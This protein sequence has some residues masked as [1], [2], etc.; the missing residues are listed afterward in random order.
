MAARQRPAKRKKKPSRLQKY[1]RTGTLVFTLLMTV[2]FGY[3]IYSL[4]FIAPRAK[5]EAAEIEEQLRIQQEEEEQRRLQ[6]EAELA[7][8]AEERRKQE[9]YE[10][11]VNEEL[12]KN[13]L[14]ARYSDASEMLVTGIGDSVM[15]GAINELY[16]TFP[17]GY[18]DAV[19]GRT[20]YSGKG[21]ISAM[22]DN[23]TL[24]EVVVFNLGTNSYI[25][26][27][28]IEELVS[29]CDDRPT[30]WITTYGVSNDSTEK[31]RAVAQQNDHVH[32]VE[33]GALA[34][35]H[36]NSYILADGLHPTHEG[37]LA[38]AE[39][40]KETINQEVLT[41]KITPEGNS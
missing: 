9:E 7:A 33:W 5:V 27:S 23:G 35:E 14:L 12:E 21:V 2:F 32:I 22:K 30:F 25:E 8:L 26:E 1:L 10:R 13:P 31:M 24:G 16:E 6:R 3:G 17:N 4:F 37:S 18:F 15:L 28:D 38:Y 29:L 41:S 19:F 34:S 40:I 20:L 11:L 39:L 36:S